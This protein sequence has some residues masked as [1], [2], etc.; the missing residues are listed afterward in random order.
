[1]DDY[2]LVKGRYGEMAEVEL[3]EDGT[4]SLEAL[5]CHFGPLVVSM[6]YRNETTGLDRYVRVTEN[7][8]LPPRDGWGGRTY[9][10]ITQEEREG[11]KRPP[12]SLHQHPLIKL[13]TKLSDGHGTEVETDS[14]PVQDQAVKAGT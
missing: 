10:T 4:V 9:T 7:H 14:Q 2:I 5:K 11:S 3:E 1:M 13:E 12:D 8:F 6:K